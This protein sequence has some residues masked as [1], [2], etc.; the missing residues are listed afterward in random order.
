MAL[1]AQKDI[2]IGGGLCGI[3]GE[4]HDV[5]SGQCAA[6]AKALPRQPPQPVAADR[7]SHL[8]FGDRKT[9]ARYTT[10]VGTEEDREVA[11]GGASAVLE[12]PVKGGGREQPLASG[13]ALGGHPFQSDREA[14]AAFC[15]ATLQNQTSAAGCHA[16]A[17]AMRADALQF[18]WLIGSFHDDNPWKNRRKTKG[19]NATESAEG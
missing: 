12:D 19:W 3:P 17:K 14:G 18:A 10:V 15:A 16:G 1:K 8:L 4:D 5:H 2:A 9:E 6:T 13:K 7:T 11:V